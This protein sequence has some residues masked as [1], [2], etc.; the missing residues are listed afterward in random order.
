MEDIATE[1]CAKRGKNRGEGKSK[2]AAG[3]AVIDQTDSL[4]VL[5]LSKAMVEMKASLHRYP[6]VTLTL[7]QSLHFDPVT[8]AALALLT[9]H[10]LPCWSPQPP[11]H[12]F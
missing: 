12:L 9:S 10:H 11:R 3:R 4:M 2:T 7:G 5:I 6:A 1:N 8:S